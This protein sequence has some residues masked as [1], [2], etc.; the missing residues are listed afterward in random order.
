MSQEAKQRLR[1]SQEEK[2]DQIKMR[3]KSH[4]FKFGKKSELNLKLA[5]YRARSAE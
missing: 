5:L 1:Q 2:K 3:R 4:L